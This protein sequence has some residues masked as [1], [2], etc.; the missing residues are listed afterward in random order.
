MK[1]SNIPTRESTSSSSN[2]STSK[3]TCASNNDDEKQSDKDKADRR[4]KIMMSTLKEAS[5][6][7]EERVKSAKQQNE[8]LKQLETKYEKN[9]KIEQNTTTL[10][11]KK[12]AVKAPNELLQEVDILLN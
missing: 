6:K 5:L 4:Y 10:E 2:P 3:M 11:L 9:S 12:N 8:F 7:E 1:K